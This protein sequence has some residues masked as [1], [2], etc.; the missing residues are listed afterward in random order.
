VAPDA[1][2]RRV[3]TA[4]WADRHGP[5]QGGAGWPFDLRDGLVPLRPCRCNTS[6]GCSVWQLNVAFDFSG[7]SVGW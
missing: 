3:A 7:I 2:L 4:G 1:V 6:C 5:R